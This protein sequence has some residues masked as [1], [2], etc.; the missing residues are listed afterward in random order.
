MELRVKTQG[1]EVYPRHIHVKVPMMLGD[2]WVSI[3]D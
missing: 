2:P 3:C 1:M